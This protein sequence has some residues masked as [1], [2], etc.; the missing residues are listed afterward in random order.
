MKWQ[1]R[2]GKLLTRTGSIKSSSSSGSHR[3]SSRRHF[4]AWPSKLRLLQ[5]WVTSGVSGCFD[6]LVLIL[7]RRYLNKRT[8]FQFVFRSLADCIP[9]KPLRNLSHSCRSAWRR[10]L[11]PLQCISGTQ[12]YFSHSQSASGA[13]LFC[14]GLSLLPQ[15]CAVPLHNKSYLRANRSKLNASGS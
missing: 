1:H 7:R 15:R 13:V 8:F 3:C 14:G 10:T 11:E 6:I 4:F 5:I 12:E 9:D 2:S